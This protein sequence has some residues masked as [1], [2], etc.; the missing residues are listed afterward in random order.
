MPALVLLY[1]FRQRRPRP[2]Q[3]HLPQQHVVDLRQL[4]QAEAADE[5]AGARQTGVSLDLEQRAVSL[6][7]LPQGLFLQVGVVNHGA[8]FVHRKPPPLAAD[9]RRGIEHRPRRIELDQQRDYPHDDERHWGQQDD[10]GQVER[11]LED[12]AGRADV[13]EGF[14][15]AHT[16][17]GDAGHVGE[18]H[19][20]EAQ[21]QQIGHHLRPHGMLLAHLQQLQQW[22]VHGPRQGDEDE[23][24][25]S[26][27]CQSAL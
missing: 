10:N 16:Q 24:D 7:Q 5:T 12:A 8:E 23:V 15:V 9:A 11:P 3:T 6:V 20:V 27:L 19:P 17:Q 22:R 1:L 26:M 4:V 14:D 18:L 2:H 21:L 13:A 25:G